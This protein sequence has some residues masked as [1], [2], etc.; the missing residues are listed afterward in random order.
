MHCKSCQLSRSCCRRLTKLPWE[1]NPEFFTDNL[2]TS[3]R[4]LV[5][6][7]L[8]RN[9]AGRKPMSTVLHSPLFTSDDGPGG[10]NAESQT[11]VT[12]FTAIFS[13]Y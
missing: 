2:P 7:L 6:D 3:A 4:N 8:Q 5:A 12:N 9:P 11:Q 10:A 1:E 13:D